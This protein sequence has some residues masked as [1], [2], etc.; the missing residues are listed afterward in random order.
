MS[1]NANFAGAFPAMGRKLRLGVVGGGAGAFIGQVH[2]RGARLSD[3]WQIVA[4]ALSSRPEVALASG[5]DWGW[6]PTA[7]IPTG[8]RWRGPRRRG[9]T[10]STRWRSPSRT[11][12]IS[13][14]PWLSWTRAST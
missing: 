8:A 11:I 4:G 10:A 3:R 5:R 12:C 7:A 2:A 14:S 1:K 6:S 13:R 9:R